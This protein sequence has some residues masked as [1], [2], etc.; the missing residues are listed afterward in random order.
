MPRS[1]DI[2]SD[3]SG[4]SIIEVLVALLVFAFIAAAMG[5]TLTSV[6]RSTE[7]ARLKEV[8]S[9]LASAKLD[10]LMAIDDT[11]DLDDIPPTTTVVDGLTYTVT[12]SVG[13]VTSTG[14]TAACG[15]GGG[16]L[17]FKRAN[18]SV[19]WA[20]MGRTPA[21]TLGTVLAPTERVNDPAYGTILV[22]V[23]GFDGT[24]RSGVSVTASG[25]ASQTTDAQGCSYLLK[26]S[27]GTYT[28]G[29]SRIGYIDTNQSTTPSVQ[30]TVSAGGAAT[31]SFE[32]D[33]AAS[34]SHT[35]A[36]NVP[37][38]APMISPTMAMTY[39]SGSLTSVVS[40]AAS[41][42]TRYPFAAG[43]QLIAGNSTTCAANDPVN[44]P[45]TADYYAGQRGAVVSA[46]P[47]S[48]STA[49]VPMGVVT[50]TMGSSNSGTLQAVQ[51]NT[52]SPSCASPL[53]LSFGT[54]SASQ[55]VRLA[56]PFGTW[57]L[58]TVKSGATTPV[59]SV[60]IVGST[61]NLVNGVLTGG[62][63]PGGSSTSGATFT[64]DP[65]V[66]K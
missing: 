28:I 48:S 14:S 59:S 44:W 11:I 35:Y 50:A 64:L 20:D 66:A 27:P 47:G 3:E 19:T 33:N 29:V 63:L 31:A 34:I 37:G 62:G 8:A 13:W 9:N 53:T 57:K 51:Q 18:V 22:R 7:E 32:F 60:T 36:T 42:T 49:A 61:V 23:Y 4:L 38:A 2:R 6:L 21:V 39:V 40:P 30:R 56:L 17:L 52:G 58:Q 10:E 24:P 15:T 26:V 16:T 25:V 1:R 5:A 12:T 54:V 43:Y 45:E 65:R 41:P 55:N 46:T